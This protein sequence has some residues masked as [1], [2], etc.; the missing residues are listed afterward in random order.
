MEHDGQPAILC[1]AHLGWDYVWQRPQHLLSR[2]AC[3]WPVAYL[4]EPGLC[5]QSEGEPRLELVAEGDGLT[6]WQPVFPYRPAILDGWR[7]S[8]VA[9][10]W[11]LLERLGWAR[12]LGERLQ[13]TR[14]LIL[15]FYT[16][17]PVYL[18]DHVPHAVVVYDVMDDLASFKGAAT[19]LR[20]REARLLAR[21]DLVF[22]GGRSLYEARRQRHAN[23]HLFASGVDADHFARARDTATPVAA[24][25]AS[26]PR[27]V[28]G[29]YGVIDERLDLDL[30]ASLAA[31][32]PEWSI[33]LV[34][35][36]TKIAPDR[37]PHL[38]NLH[39]P[40]RQPYARLPEFLKGFDVC[41]MPFALNEATRFISPTKALEYMAAHKPV[42][43]T[44]VPDVTANWSDAV[45]VASGECFAAAIEAAFAETTAE[46][47]A[48]IA[49][50]QAHVER[51]GWDGISAAMA[52]LIEAA[53]RRGRWSVI[54]DAAA[55]TEQA[56]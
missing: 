33:A 53:W 9:T 7:D 3:R 36:V 48:R 38:P 45:R 47:A 14:P 37:L 34:G 39:Y 49:R 32:R 23:V 8:Y 22:A 4:N 56:L 29:Y 26:L 1:L 44:P 19:D 21:A 46:R 42:V 2:L 31:S 43:S 18:L 52:S 11:D 25:V 5:D 41:L 35:P 28:L 10:V 20:Q 13:P 55:G 15:W 6:A 54:P 40:G 27:P 16:P 51:S 50:Q 12:R 17:T 30:I 24:E